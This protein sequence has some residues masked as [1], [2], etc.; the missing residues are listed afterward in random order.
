MLSSTD[1][2][3]LYVKAPIE[4]LIEGN[5]VLS[6]SG[7]KHSTEGTYCT[8]LLLC[9]VFTEEMTQVPEMMAVSA[10]SS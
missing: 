1:P 5:G 10:S 6:R 8:F 7:P 4:L 9:C 2:T 3:Q